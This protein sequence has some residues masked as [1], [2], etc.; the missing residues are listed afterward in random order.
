MC[1]FRRHSLRESCGCSSQKHNILE[2]TFLLACDCSSTMVWNFGSKFLKFRSPPAKHKSPR[3]FWFLSNICNFGQNLFKSSYN[4]LKI[5]K[6]LAKKFWNY[7]KFWW[8]QFFQSPQAKNHVSKF[9][10]LSPTHVA[11]E[12]NMDYG[13]AWRPFI[14]SLI[15]RINNTYYMV[16]TYFTYS[17]NKING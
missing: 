5:Q 13:Y 8:F 12:L 2:Y 15:N 6:T 10:T 17:F 4:M 9:K 3:I 14:V 11:I 7:L 1:L 16:F